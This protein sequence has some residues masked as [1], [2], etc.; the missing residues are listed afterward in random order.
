MT[1]PRVKDRLAEIEK[2]LL[3][4]RDPNKLFPE[5]SKVQ[6]KTDVYNWPIL[7][8]KYRNFLA[9]R[10]PVPPEFLIIAS[11]LTKKTNS[12]LKNSRNRALSVLACSI[13][14]YCRVIDIS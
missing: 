5:L 3:E 8:F 10:I 11:E 1:L 7:P 14:D 6:S 13:L 9:S 4:S 12:R 2:K